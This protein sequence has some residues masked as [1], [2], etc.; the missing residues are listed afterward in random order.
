MVAGDRND[1]FTDAVVTFLADAVRRP[2]RET[3]MRRRLVVTVLGDRCCWRSACGAVR[4]LWLTG[5]FRRINP[6]FAGTC[7]LVPGPVGPEDITIHPRTGVAYVSATDR[8]AWNSRRPVP[9][10]IYAYDL[11]AEHPAVVNLTP[12]ADSAL[13]A[14]R[15]QPLDR[16][17]RP[18]RALRR[19][20]PDDRR[21]PGAEHVEIFDVTDDA[22]DPPRDPHRPA[23]R[24]AERHRRGRARPLLRDQHAPLPAGPHAD[25]RDVS[26][27]VG[28]AGALLRSGRI[29]AGDHGPRA[30]ER[31]QREPGRQDRS[32][33]RRRP[34][35]RCAS[36]TATRETET[37]RSGRRFRCG[38]GADNIEID[39]HGNLWIG[40]HPK[41]LKIEAH[42]KDPTTLS[43]SQVLR[44]TPEGT[45][46]RDLPRRRQLISTSTV[47][48]V[49]GNRSDRQRLR[50]RLPR[51]ARWPPTAAPRRNCTATD[52]R[53]R[54]RR[55]FVP[56]AARGSG[57]PPGRLAAHGRIGLDVDR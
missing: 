16:P 37:L 20:P 7:H 15:H 57:T 25:D 49:R 51:S 27:A 14:A 46:R 31:H 30:P 26:A 41:L 50:R 11:N 12:H 34:A 48:A 43:P 54:G 44:I 40:A 22:L 5:T 29:P 38:S 18:R 23:A 28:G 32:T 47:G 24:H 21:P 36:T 6:H 33:S 52:R 19:E 53:K 42:G 35:A 45:S 13:P 9:G 39:E 2:D 1:L 17:R 56:G 3:R 8:R 55:D 4:L 10:A